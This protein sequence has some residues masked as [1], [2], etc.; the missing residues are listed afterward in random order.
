MSGAI[1]LVL[2]LAAAV[3]WV[4]GMVFAYVMLRPAAGALLEPPLR[5]RLWAAV[6]GRFFAWV[7]AAV[8]VL[9]ASG[10]WMLFAL[11]G[12][13]GAAGWHVH[14]ML[15]LG[16]VMMLL[17]AHVYFAPFP[18]LRR[19]VAAGD[20]AAGGKALDQIRKVVAVNTM[21]GTI[22]IAVAAAGRYL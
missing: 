6:L 17:F 12:G 10:F 11:F 19:A 20:A 5:Q 21:L 3:V 8:V 15:A 7:W 13:F 18:R 16:V 22:V 2:H 14:V 4:G 9:L 1:A